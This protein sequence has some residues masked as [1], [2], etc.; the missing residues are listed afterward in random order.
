MIAI[1]GDVHGC[2]YTLQSLVEKIREKYPDIAI[3]CVGDLVD[4]GNH[5]FEVFEYMINEKIVFTPGN[6]DFMFY[7]S[8]RDPNSLMAKSWKYNGAETTLSSYK[9]RLDRL[10]E[11]LNL[12]ASS[13]L[14]LNLDDCF[15]SHAG[16]SLHLAEKLPDNFLKN[17]IELEKILREDMF[18]QDSIIWAR[19]KLLNIGKLQV[20]GHT[21]RDTIF[22]DKD[23]DVL[24]ID[25]TAYGNN[26]LTAV[27]IEQ[28][29]LIDTLDEKTFSDDISKNWSFYV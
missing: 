25:T 12:I 21:H 24:Y 11:H 1:I 13:P 27:I 19:G 9:N 16:I 7:S 22:F 26:K 29:K 14:F 4:R 18:E 8:F 6:H 10:D 5:S 2:F 23:S 3:Y 15:I 20:V 28:N 17:Q